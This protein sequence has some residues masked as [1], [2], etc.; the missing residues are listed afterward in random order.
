MPQYLPFNETNIK[1]VFNVNVTGDFTS[2]T[3]IP[4]GATSTPVASDNIVSLAMD[5]AVEAY[6]LDSFAMT[7]TNEFNT[8]AAGTIEVLLQTSTSGTLDTTATWTTIGTATSVAGATPTI[9]LT[10]T[11]IPVGTFVRL[12]PTS[13]GTV[14]PSF[15][16]EVNGTRF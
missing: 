7:I 13:F 16:V 9:S 11:A 6:S 4:F 5:R 12:R 1:E 15:H 10:T 2:L 3:P 8:T 14:T